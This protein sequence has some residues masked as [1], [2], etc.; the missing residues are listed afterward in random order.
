MAAHAQPIHSASLAAALDYAS[1][2]IAVLPVWAVRPDGACRCQAGAKCPKPG[3]H[4]FN[5]GWQNSAAVNASSI[6][7]D[8]PKGAVN[9]AAHLGKSELVC[10]DVDPRNSGVSSLAQLEALLGLSL[11]NASACVVD[12]GRGDGGQHL[13]FA[14]SQVTDEH[15][16]SLKRLLGVE[17]PGLDLLFGNRY[18]ILPPSIHASGG[19]YRLAR[20][21][22]DPAFLTALPEPL[23]ALTAASEK[24]VE[25]SMGTSQPDSGANFFRAVNNAA[26]A[27]L[28]AWVPSVLPAACKR[29]D[30]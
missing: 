14:R 11:Y 3:K 9:L 24:P 25:Q 6:R 10:L 23:L 22:L 28:E 27:D 4:P 12:T 13:Y 26:L 7:R 5:Y 1:A 20:G 8:W 18:T 15:L 19:T 30:G 21:E 29:R 16:L 17:Y 2:G